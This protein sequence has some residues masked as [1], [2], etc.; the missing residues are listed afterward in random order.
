MSDFNVG[1]M[2]AGS[3]GCYLG[4]ALAASGVPVVCIARDRV[5]AEV[6]AHGVTLEGLSGAPRRVPLERL[7][8]TGDPA[9]LASCDAVLC[10][11]KSAQTIE[12]GEALARVL[13]QSALVVSAQNGVGNADALRR[14]P[15]SALPTR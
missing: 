2:G 13:P 11:V 4:G 9:A 12:A 5:R 3:I 1:I 14:T 7:A 10:C 6:A 8:F 15:Q